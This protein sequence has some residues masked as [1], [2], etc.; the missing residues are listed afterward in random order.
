VTSLKATL[1][2]LM[3]LL[4]IVLLIRSYNV[5]RFSWT[6]FHNPELTAP[7]PFSVIIPDHAS[8]SEI[9]ARYADARQ[10]YIVEER[11][12]GRHGLTVAASTAAAGFAALALSAIPWRRVSRRKAQCDRAAAP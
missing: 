6:R 4:A 5:G 1:R 11:A 3:L 12:L 9:H 8:Q 2:L 7:G 10:P